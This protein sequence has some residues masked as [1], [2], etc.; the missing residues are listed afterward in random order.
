MSELDSV[1]GDVLA[2]LRAAVVASG[3][4]LGKPVREHNRQMNKVREECARLAS[5]PAGREALTRAAEADPDPR[6]R[7][8]AAVAVE[9]WNP[10]KAAETL[11]DLIA[12][13]G[14]T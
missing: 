9:T 13:A 5:T 11:V 6:V 14:G 7:L 8:T 12:A 1:Y 10:A 3:G 4:R 2:G